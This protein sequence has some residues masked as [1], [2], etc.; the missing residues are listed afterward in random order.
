MRGWGTSRA[1]GHSQGPSASP[2]ARGTGLWRCQSPPTQ[3][4]VWA[5]P[6]CPGE[7]NERLNSWALLPHLPTE[8]ANGSRAEASGGAGE[9]PEMDEADQCSDPTCLPVLCITKDHHCCHFIPLTGCCQAA[10]GNISLGE[11]KNPLVL[12]QPLP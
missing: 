3:R 4:R 9:A 10:L 12:L 11:Q 7:Q 2:V 6:P 1:L 5:L 8:V